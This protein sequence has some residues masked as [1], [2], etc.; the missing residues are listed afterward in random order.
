MQVHIFFKNPKIFFFYNTKTS[1]HENLHVKTEHEQILSSK[2]TLNWS[3]MVVNFKFLWR[4][5]LNNTQPKQWKWRN[6]HRLAHTGFCLGGW[7][8]GS[9]VNSN[10]MI[11]FC[12]FPVL[13]KTTYMLV[14][15]L[16]FSAIQQIRGGYKKACDPHFN[17]KCPCKNSLLSLK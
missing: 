10:D 15:S 3:W 7:G 14:L 1:L 12:F 13:S 8:W 5:I 2:V 11:L 6:T 9:I 4:L 16:P 17:V